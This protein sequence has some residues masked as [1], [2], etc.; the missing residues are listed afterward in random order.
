MPPVQR[1]EDRDKM[2]AAR[3]R[4][5]ADWLMGHGMSSNAAQS[6][7][8]AWE[9][10]AVT[11]GLHPQSLDF[12]KDAGPWIAERLRAGGAPT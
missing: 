10:E 11:R 9:A 5:V 4:A 1:Y 7:C 12:W 6:W 8:D 3:R 2:P